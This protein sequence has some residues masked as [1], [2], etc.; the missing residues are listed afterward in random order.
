MQ[1][2]FD[3]YFDYLDRIAFSPTK[4]RVSVKVVK[5]ISAGSFPRVFKDSSAGSFPNAYYANNTIF[6][7]HRLADD[8]SVPLREYNHHLLNASAGSKAWSGH[9]AALEFGLAD[10]FSCSFL[11]NPRLGEKAANFF[12]ELGRPYIRNLD[13]D[14]QFTELAKTTSPEYPYLGAEIW[15]GAFWE[16]R[17]RLSRN[18]ADGLLASVWL[19]FSFPDRD[20]DIPAAFVKAALAQAMKSDKRFYDILLASFRQRKFPVQ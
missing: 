1:A 11:N 12:K 16:M 17:E 9:Y 2:L 19:N 15:G 6:I 4:Q 20:E 10:Y 13:N 14:R 18:V 7:D 5:D 8:P 3:K